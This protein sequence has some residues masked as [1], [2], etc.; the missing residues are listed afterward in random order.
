MFDG[1]DSPDYRLFADAYGQLR[2]NPFW[3]RKPG[4]KPR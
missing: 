2:D 3:T 1:P 4:R